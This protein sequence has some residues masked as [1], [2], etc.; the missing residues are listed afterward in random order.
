[1][2]GRRIGA[3]F[4][5]LALLLTAC[6]TTSPGTSTQLNSWDNIVAQAKG[7]TVNWYMWS[8]DDHINA[9]VDKWVGDKAKQFGVTVQRVPVTDTVDAVT[10]VLNE[11]Q[12]GQNTN[13]SVDLIWANGENF[14]TGKQA[15]L[16]YCGYNDLLPNNK[17]VNWNNASVAYDFGI[18]V[19]KCEA[20][21][22]H[23]QF[24]FV[25]DSARV[26][27]PPS[28][29]ADLITWI[30][31]HPGRFTYPAPP[32]FTGSVFVR[33]VL[34]QVAGGYQGLLGP[35]DQS[36]YDKYTPQLW[37]VLNDI[38]SSLWRKG[39]TYPQS[40]DQLNS[41]FG[42]GEIDFTMTY[43]AGGI[44]GLVH[45]GIFPKTTRELVFKEGT[46]GNTHYVGI[47]YNSPHKAAAMVVANILGSPE[48]QYQKDLPDV[49]GDYPAIDVTKA[50]DWTAKFAA[51]PV[52]PS[53]LPLDQ[54]AKNS[55]PELN[56]KW[57][58]AVEDGWK[59]NVL[60]KS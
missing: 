38:K 3:L 9:Y 11:K 1:M 18:P 37:T 10:K 39:S 50:G 55:N 6:G 59:R 45:K 36:K 43:G 7:Q 8:G 27:N 12:A 56:A 32:D 19:D 53:T 46:I 4:Y 20:P 5:T 22:G 31:A 54:L 41:L 58:T 30:K 44:P 25:Y 14:L 13:G 49:W 51:I 34:Y 28:T 57:V 26:P 35:F 16:W 15:N 47:P 24:V 21:W 29:M 42:N 52:D 33:H 23:A 2:S 40:I 60:Q 48:A 17:Y